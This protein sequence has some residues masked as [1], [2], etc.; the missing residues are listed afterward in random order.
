MWTEIDSPI[1]PLRLIGNGPALTGV[2]LSPHKYGPE[3][4]P[5]NEHGTDPVL[6][7]AARQLGAYF[8]GTLTEF[9][10]PLEPDGT[11]FQRAVWHA[12]QEIP[13]GGTRSYVD[14]ARRLGDAKKTRAV[15]LANGRNPISI[16]IPCHRVIGANGSLVGY[17]G[18]LERKR[19]LLHHELTHS[20]LFV[21]TPLSPKS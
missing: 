18:G 3:E 13:Y 10:L 21:Q 8:E 5:E 17:G 12:L 20:S 6:L 16:I 15:G 2:F 11:E 14:L 19:W 1:G 9:Q 7:E 4:W